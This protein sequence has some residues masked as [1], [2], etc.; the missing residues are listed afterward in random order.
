MHISRRNLS[1]AI[2]GLTLAGC[3]VS[4]SNGVTT[5]TVSL[6]T[7]DAYAQAIKNAVTLLLANPLIAAALGTATVAAI[8]AAVADVST[9]IASLDAA[10]NGQAQLVFDA[11]SIPAALTSL[12]DDAAQILGYVQTVVAALG[13]KLDATVTQAFNAFATI[14]SLLQVVGSAVVSARA[15]AMSEAQALAVLGVK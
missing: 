11:S 1:L 9:S 14:V 7:L 5:G 12:Q 15:G 10:D 13:A 4:T 2:V 3:T 6:K 8:N